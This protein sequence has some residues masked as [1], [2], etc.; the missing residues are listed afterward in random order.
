ITGYDSTT[1]VV[2]YQYQLT[3]P[4]TDVPDVAETDTFVV[5]VSDGTA[6]ASGNLVI[7]IVDD[8][9]SAQND[10]VSLSEDTASVSGN[11]LGNDTIGADVSGSVTTT[12]NQA[13]SYG[14][15]TLNADGTFSYVLN[16]GLAAVQGLDSSE[17]LTETFNYSMQDADGDPSSATLTITITGNNDGPTLSVVGATV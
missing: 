4:T 9:P 3:S 15:L 12:G 7:T 16:T 17:T 8:V 2:S 10:S 5:S 1:G 11:V 6:S 13:G 14:T